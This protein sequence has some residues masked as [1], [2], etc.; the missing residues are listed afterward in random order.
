M[1]TSQ[2]DGNKSKITYVRNV[3]EQPIE[4]VDPLERKTTRTFDAA[5]NLKTLKDPDGRTT[6]YS[7][8]KADRLTGIS[9]SDGVTPNA[10]F[11]C[12][13]DG[14]LTSMVD[15]TGTSTYEY[16]QLGR[17]TESEAEPAKRLPG[18]TTSA[19]SQSA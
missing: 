5:G 11:G 6:T 4:T 9:Y 1:V 7:Y 10:T 16:D 18:N 19:I 17:L 8:D 15:G 13:K 3:L 12:D 2:T 14:N